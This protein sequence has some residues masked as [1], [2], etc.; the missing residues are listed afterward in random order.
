MRL[1]LS[2]C[3]VRVSVLLL[4][5]CA[6]LQ[7]SPVNAEPLGNP[8][9]ILGVSRKADSKEIKR[10]YKNLVREWHPDKTN[11]PEAEAKF[12]EITRA[13]E[14]LSD[15]ER[16]KKFDY[17]GITEE[18]IPVHKRENR[19]DGG[20][21]FEDLLSGFNKFH[22]Q[23][24]DIS[25]FHEM[26]ITYKAFENT[27]IPKSYRMPHLILIYSDWCFACLQVEP[28]WRRLIDELEPFGISLHTV[29][30]Q[31]ETALLNKLGVRSLPYLVLTIDGHTFA[32]KET[33]FSV[34]KIVDFLRSKFP[35][36]LLH[37]INDDNVENFLN[38]WTDN[39]IRALIFE[40][41]DKPR[42]RYLAVA[43][44]HR[45]HVTFGFVQTGSKKAKGIMEKYKISQDA[46]TLLLFNE[47]V[48]K[49]VASISMQ[50]I[51]T[52]T[53]HNIINSNRFLILPRLSNQAMLD[54]VCPQV[55]QN[56]RKHLC[57]VLITENTNEYETMRHKFRQ[58]ALAAPHSPE[59]VRY[60][61]LFKET[62]PQ[63]LSALMAS[64]SSP[65]D[66]LHH[67]VI[68]W[69]RDSSH[70]KYEW[71]KSAWS[72]VTSNEDQ[73]NQ[74]RLNLEQNIKKLLRSNE[75]LP[76]AAE[77]QELSDEHALSRNE[78]LIKKTIMMFDY[79]L[80]NCT[81]AQVLSVL[82]VL[83]SFIVIVILAK[84]MTYLIAAEE[85]SIQAENEKNSEKVKTPTVQ[86]TQ[87][88]LKL[89]EMRTE[90]Y[91]RLVR[92]LKPGCRTIVLLVDKDSKL[93]LIPAFHKAVWPY[94]KNVPLMFCH[95]S[96]ERGLEWY[97]NL[98]TL[99][100]PEERN[101]KI[102]A[103]NCVG[104]VLSLNGHRKYFCMYHAKHPESKKGKGNKRME[105]MT[106]RLAHPNDA[107]SGAFIGFDSSS[108]S[109]CETQEI[110]F[111]ENLLEG[112]PMWL[113]RLFEGSTQRY[114]VNYWPDFPVR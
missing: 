76:Y 105:R 96:M 83:G 16:R 20:D 17:H 58:A 78:K 110:L 114:Y 4:G 45:D 90:T 23:S 18:G 28:I 34:Q 36:K 113:D 62:Q 43:L 33:L 13:Y 55:W 52:D 22:Y 32:Y 71:F 47:N 49:P 88:Q 29:H 77:V 72:Q 60:A 51:S 24:R 42:I 111:T 53:M 19:F 102:N 106:K 27:V 108:D 95:L 70:V 86:V 107:E 7:L 38:G 81:R 68:I 75:A 84:A 103:K 92:L 10:A 46:D 79:I 25:L 15:P 8:Y 64:E 89:Y 30:A 101:L 73:W 100:L 87:K 14:L 93:K 91:N 48:E 37:K 66:P 39:R 57:A 109:D 1:N 41:K 56:S 80:E 2:S 67:I 65:S 9:N 11:H 94:R 12:V 35:Y 59:R 97:K 112:L 69:R 40:N 98:L 99:C 104:T 85:A 31:K 44:Q 21:P 26:S 74:T 6:T 54:S 63:F 3:A 5:L 61:Y 50:D 82:S